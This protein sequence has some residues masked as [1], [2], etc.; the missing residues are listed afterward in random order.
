MLNGPLAGIGLTHLRVYGQR[1]A[2]D[3]V[4]CGC[5]HVHAITHEAYY[6]L[7]GTGA[8][9]LHDTAHGFRTVELT[10]GKLVQFAPNTLHRAVNTGD[11]TALVLM[12]NAGLAERGDAR[13]WF[14]PEVDADPDAYAALWRLPAEKGLDGAL[15]RR[16][17]A[18]TAYMALL[19]L[20]EADRPAYFAELARFFDLHA[21]AVEPLRP[22]FADIVAN[23]P[24][25]WVDETVGV[26][27]ALPV[28]VGEADAIAV[29][30]PSGEP[31]YGMCGLLGQLEQTSNV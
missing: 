7:S 1:P 23:G 12:N 22:R 18:V 29:A 8:L 6:V 20:W 4:Q 25:A 2:P 13:I 19:A 11:L 10:P 9:E 30:P 28:R 16:D 17:A 14:G 15:E 21:R 27:G 5:P 24:K 31:R 3:G 26:L